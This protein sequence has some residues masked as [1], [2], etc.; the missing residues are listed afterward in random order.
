[1]S[2]IQVSPAS[3]TQNQNLPFAEP[4]VSFP[5]FAWK[6]VSLHMIT[7]TVIGA[8]VSFVFN[9]KAL[10]ASAEFSCLMRSFDSPWVVAGPALNCVRGL[11]FAAVLY[12]FLG[13]FLN[14]RHGGLLLWSLFLGL[15]IFGQVGPSPGSLEGII[16]TK[17]PLI[18]HLTTLP[19]VMVQTLLFSTGLIAWCRRPSRWKDIAAGIGVA[20]VLCTSALGIIAAR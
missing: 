4:R 16:F 18:G 11:L 8:V 12:S 14:H 10:F 15:S 5:R 9:Y 17:V 6:V 13:F 19:E 3:L 2:E 1:M 20:L 7:Y